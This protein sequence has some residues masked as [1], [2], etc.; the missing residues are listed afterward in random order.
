M[1]VSFLQFVGLLL[2]ENFLNSQVSGYVYSASRTIQYSLASVLTAIP[3]L[4]FAT[5]GLFL[6]LYMHHSWGVVGTVMA[7]SQVARHIL[8]STM[9]A[10]WILFLWMIVTFYIVSREMEVA[11]Q[12]KN[13]LDCSEIITLHR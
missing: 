2:D 6:V 7:H 13:H 1:V 4:L 8:R 11:L 10:S 3:I 9:L 5:V 12:M